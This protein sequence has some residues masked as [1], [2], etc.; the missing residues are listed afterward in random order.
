ME[1]GYF[2]WANL[3]E[4][5]YMKEEVPWKILINLNQYME[6][7]AE[8]YKNNSDYIKIDGNIIHKSAIVDKTAKVTNCFV[9]AKVYIYEGVS[10][11]NSVIFDYS[12]IGHA[13]EVARSVILKH[14]S[15]PRFDYVG[16]SFLGESVRLGG[17]VSFATRRH[18]D[19]DVCI[20]YGNLIIKTDQNKFGSLI[21]DNTKIGYGVHLNPGTVVGNDCLIMPYVDLSGSIGEKSIVYNKTQVAIREK[22]NFVDISKLME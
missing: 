22:R 1:K 12:V 11:R 18:D 13:S 9:G 16:G 17:C 20:S 15:I 4:Y 2:Y 7:L 21:G 10:V 5:P 19:K 8:K 6:Q 3:C 14:C